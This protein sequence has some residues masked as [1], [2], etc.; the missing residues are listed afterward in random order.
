LKRRFDLENDA[1]LEPETFDLVLN[2]GTTEHVLNQFNAFRILH[3][4]AK[5]GGL[6][7]S[8]FIRAGH[9]EHGLL[10]YSDR[11][12]DLWMRFNEYEQVWRQDHNAKGEECT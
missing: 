2:F 5:P 4:L 7:Y 9:M 1:P 10:H 6:I 12:V 3:E 8:Y 11:F